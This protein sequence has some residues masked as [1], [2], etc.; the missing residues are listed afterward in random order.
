MPDLVGQHSA[1]TYFVSE[2]KE[3]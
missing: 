2:Y 3:Q 1:N